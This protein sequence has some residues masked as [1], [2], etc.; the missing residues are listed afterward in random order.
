MMIH[1]LTLKVMLHGTIFND[2]F[3]RNAVLQCSNNVATFRN[4]VA[5]LSS[6]L[7]LKSS[8]LIDV[9]HVLKSKV[10]LMLF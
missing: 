4:N 1:L 2:D 6:V 5:T 7:C 8:L 3:E 10:S 9:F